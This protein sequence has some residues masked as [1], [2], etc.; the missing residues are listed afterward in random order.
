MRLTRISQDQLDAVSPG[1]SV[2]H[3]KRC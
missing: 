3:N 2:H 1:G